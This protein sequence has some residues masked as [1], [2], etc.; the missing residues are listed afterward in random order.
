VQDMLKH[1]DDWGGPSTYPHMAAGW[2][3]AGDTPFMWTKQIP[4]NYGGTRNGMIV[5]W[6]RRIKAAN[7]MRSQWHHVID[8]APT[9]LEAAGLPEP[10]SVNGVVQEP[11]EGVSMVYTFDNAQAK[12]THTTQYFEILGN[13]GIYQDGW[14]AGTLHRAPWETVPR[15]KLPEDIWE[16]YDTTKDFSLANDLAATNPA[17][18]KE[19]QDLFIKEA[20]KCRVLPI[21]DRTLERY[22][23]ALVGRPDV[24]EGRTSL[25]LSAGMMAMSENVFINVKNRSLSI[26]A[27]VEIPAGGANGVILAQGGRFG[28][29]SLYLKDG[30]PTY[31]YNFLGLQQ[32]KVSAPQ[33]LAAGKATIRMNFDYAGG[34]IGKGG[35]VTLLVNGAKA[36]SGQIEHTEGMIFSGDETADVGLDDATPASTDYKE[37]DNTFTGKIL[38]VTVDVK[39]IGAAAKA[40]ADSGQRMAAV[41]KALSD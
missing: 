20:I 27:E 39:P 7:E 23:A 32:F 29:W 24:M 36:A 18:L 28:G 19:L 33:A 31:C 3:V 34:G 35:T 30:K 22:N 9:I 41:K 1:Y 13:R 8:V 16:L 21:D 6:P 26:T 10:K 17:K 37:Y 11:I 5:S 38:K 2:A 15:R 14:F 40:Q 12:S 25:T 4:S